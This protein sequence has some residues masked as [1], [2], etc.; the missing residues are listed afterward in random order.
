MG[1]FAFITG[2]AVVLARF[3]R[4]GTGGVQ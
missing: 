3:V 2:F 4:D 1:V